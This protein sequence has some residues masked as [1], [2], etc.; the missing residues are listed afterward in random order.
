ML[1]HEELVLNLV[2]CTTNL[3][4]YAISD[5]EN[6]PSPLFNNP[7]KTAALIA[8]MLLHNH[9]DGVLESVRAFGNFSRI[10]SVRNWMNLEKGLY[11]W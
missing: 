10:E 1:Q 11:E 8:P 9:P 3:S 7:I 5:S 4:F 2:R 6:S